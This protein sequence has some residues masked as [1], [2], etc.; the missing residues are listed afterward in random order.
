[1]RATDLPSRRAPPPRLPCTPSRR[2]AAQLLAAPASRA[3][4]GAP[5]VHRSRWNTSA[6]QRRRIAPRQQARDALPSDFRP[7][8]GA[9]RR[10]SAARAADRERSCPLSP[11]TP[12][13][14]L[15]AR[16]RGSTEWL[17]RVRAGGQIA[18]RQGGKAA[19][20]S[21]CERRRAQSIP[22]HCAS[23]K[24]PSGRTARSRSG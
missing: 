14:W 21:S 4:R 5:R 19:R 24:K 13:C 12:P 20:C 15:P 17:D 11:S 23:R 2:A 8:G 1:M 10:A 6:P 3:P 22:R 16:S 7:R 18:S 9:G